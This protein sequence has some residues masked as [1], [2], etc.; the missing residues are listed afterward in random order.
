MFS[1]I[2]TREFILIAIN[3]HLNGSISGFTEPAAPAFHPQFPAGH[4][5]HDRLFFRIHD[6]EIRSLA[7]MAIAVHIISYDHIISGKKRTIKTIY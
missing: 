5:L 2:A 7:A 4:L 1:F 6:T 3:H